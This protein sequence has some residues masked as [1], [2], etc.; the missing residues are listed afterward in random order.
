M[1]F[2][3]ND[4]IF[5]PVSAQCKLSVD[6]EGI[7]IKNDEFCIQNDEFHFYNDDFCIKND[8]FC[9]INDGF[10]RP[11]TEYKQAQGIW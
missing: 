7:E 11:R 6:T 3:D 10:R 4:W 9:I 5:G 8:E 1:N 2:I